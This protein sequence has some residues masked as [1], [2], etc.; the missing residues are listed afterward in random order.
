M[1]KFFKLKENKTTVSTEVM[2]GV[3]TFFA[4]SYILFVNPSILSASGM[5]FQAVFLATI[6]ASV[7]GTLV[8]GLFANVPYAQAP[9][10]GLNAF[11]T[12]TVVF[13]LGYSWQQA[14]AMVFICG[15]IN[16][17]ITITKIRKL[18]IHA[19]PESMQHAIGGGIGIFVAY[20]GLKNAN[21]LSF[22]ADTAA[23]TGSTVDGDTIV[24]ASFNGGIVPA[25]ANFNNAP[26]ILAIIGL[27]LTTLLVVKNVR[28]A[29]IIGILGTT[30]IGILMGVVDLS[31][32][33][34]QGNSLGSSINEL[35][36]TFGA[37]FGPEGIGS[38]FSDSAKIPQVIMTI[39]AFSLS[40]TFDTIGTFIGTGRRT[41]IFSQK[42]EEALEDSK[43]FNTK[44]D[45]ALF[46][47]AIATSI[48]AIFGTSN[49]TTYVESA[50]GIGAGGRTGL[51]SVVVAALFAI[52]SFFSPLISVVPAQATAPALILVGVMMLASFA[53]I[54]WSDL[55]EAVP[56]FFA[57]IFMGLCYS[58]SYGIAAGFIFY[59]IVKVVKGKFREV[60]P[61]LWVVNIL[62]IL[63]FIILAVIS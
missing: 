52:S 42:D 25:L 54:N 37:A 33:D 30:I 34:W 48:G 16:I 58:I 39:I 55:E 2:A 13:G 24:S 51:T 46:A 18:I 63:N 40:D 32:I 45:K 17:L 28:G 10:M 49:T 41:G 61:I 59:A 1:E 3:T 9:G 29:I 15:V 57:S 12:F 7:I 36:T 21:L 5:P 53:D 62:F 23:V 20:V 43:G 56:A 27:V 11:F 50:A 26:V 35:G 14:L 47:D 8:M 60:S 22:S 38:L 44:M 31:T 19:I 4:M 6:I